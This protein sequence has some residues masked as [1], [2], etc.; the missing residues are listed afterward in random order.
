M[1]FLR[2]AGSNVGCSYLSSLAISA[3]LRRWKGASPS[4]LGGAGQVTNTI[5]PAN[6]PFQSAKSVSFTM[7]ATMTGAL[8]TPFVAGVHARGI[9]RSSI[10]LGAIIRTCEDSIHQPRPK[11]KPSDLTSFRPR[12]LIFSWDHRS[13]F[14]LAGELVR[15]PPISS[16][17]YAAVS[18]TSLWLK[19]ASE[20]RLIVTDSAAT[21][22]LDGAITA[23]I[24][25]ALRKKHAQKTASFIRTTQP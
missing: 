5:L 14:R 10:G 16:A 24:D 17:K 13:A 19:P 9:A 1:R 23:A 12:L 11:S 25:E 7:G 15:R 3:S 4:S 21:A 6:L 8:N 2:A 20:I 22:A 18:T